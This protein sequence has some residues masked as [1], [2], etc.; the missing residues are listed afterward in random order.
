MR[1]GRA[2]RILSSV[3]G[4]ELRTAASEGNVERVREL[5]KGKLFTSGA[6]VNSQ[7]GDGWTA[8]N[9]AAQKGHAAVVQLLVTKGADVN[10]ANVRGAAPLHTAA[11]R[12]HAAVVQYLLDSAAVLTQR[13]GRTHAQ[14]SVANP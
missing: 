11:S 2:H 12:G 5:L 4:S 8:L 3:C 13:N 1:T 14:P 9:C 7:D 10:R 6:D